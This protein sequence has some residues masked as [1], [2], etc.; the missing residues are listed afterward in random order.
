MARSSL[1]GHH[2]ADLERQPE[3]V[4]VISL[5]GVLELHLDNVV[6]TRSGHLRHIIEPV[7]TMEFA[8]RTA[9]VF[10]FHEPDPPYLAKLTERVSRITVIFTCPG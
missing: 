6:D 2:L 9:A 7:E 3:R 8:A 5:A 4:A 10:L 1:H